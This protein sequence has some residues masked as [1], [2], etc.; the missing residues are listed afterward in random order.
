MIPAPVSRVWD[1]VKG[2]GFLVAL[3]LAFAIY[4]DFAKES[5]LQAFRD[6]INDYAARLCE[7]GEGQASLRKYNGLVNALIWDTQKRKDE[8]EARG[9]FE[10]ASINATTLGKLELARIEIVKQNCNRPLLPGR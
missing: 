8:N 6:E 2:Y 1:R 4:A 9:D 3:V 5:T 7:R 10:K